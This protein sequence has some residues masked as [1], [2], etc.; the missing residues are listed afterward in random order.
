MTPNWNDIA[1]APMPDDEQAGLRLDIAAD[2]FLTAF[3]RT[4]EALE[5]HGF[6]EQAEDLCHKFISAFGGKR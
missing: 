1:A 2:N 6:G 5:R 4:V 3:R